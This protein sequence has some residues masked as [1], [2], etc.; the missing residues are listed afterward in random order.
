MDRSKKDIIFE[1]YSQGKSYSQIQKETG[2]SK[3]TISYH[4][5]VGVKEK[6]ANR[7]KQDRHKITNYIRLAKTGKVCVDCKEDY[8]PWILEFD[9]LPGTDKL[10][11]I[12][13][14]NISRDKSLEDVKAEI[15]KCEIVC[16]N[17]HKNRTYSRKLKNGTYLETTEYYENKI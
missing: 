14:H 8:P 3:G 6:A 7:R 13:Q 15:K 17:C 4:L 2:F 12:G 5:G 11:T 10:F 1:L 9:H 16:A